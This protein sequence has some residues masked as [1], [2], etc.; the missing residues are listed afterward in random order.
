MFVPSDGQIPVRF[1]ILPPTRSQI[2]TTGLSAGRPPEHPVRPLNRASLQSP[3]QC[4]LTQASL[5]FLHIERKSVKEFLIG[6]VLIDVAFKEPLID[7]M[8]LA[9]LGFQPRSPARTK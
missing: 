6:C 8:R 3:A 4:P 2:K 7:T 1:L 5:Q 9:S